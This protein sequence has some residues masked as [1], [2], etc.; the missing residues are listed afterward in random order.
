LIHVHKKDRAP[1]PT[2]LLFSIFELFGLWRAGAPWR[3]VALLA[4]S[5]AANTS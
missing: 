1:E 3:A 2:T 5:R 4:G